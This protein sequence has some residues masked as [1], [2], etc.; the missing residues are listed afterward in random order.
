MFVSLLMRRIVAR[1]GS[2]LGSSPGKDLRI[3]RLP[4]VKPPCLTW[5]GPR[6]PAFSF[7]RFTVTSSRAATLSTRLMGEPWAEANRPPLLALGE[8]IVVAGTTGRRSAGN[9]ARCSCGD[10]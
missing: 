4:D 6:D 3:L 8:S 7:Q 2:G 9:W 1:N 5:P 10:A